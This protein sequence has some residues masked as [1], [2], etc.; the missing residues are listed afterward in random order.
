M[1]SKLRHGDTH[2][3]AETSLS[4]WDKS[5]YCKCRNLIGGSSI[6]Q[7]VNLCKLRCEKYGFRLIHFCPSLCLQ[8][9]FD[10]CERMLHW[11]SYWFWWH[12]SVV[13][14]FPWGEGRWTF[15]DIWFY[16]SVPLIEGRS[17]FLF[18][19]FFNIRDHF[20][21]SQSDFKEVE[22]MLLFFTLGK[23]G[24]GQCLSFRGQKPEG[25]SSGF[26]VRSP[27]ILHVGSLQGLL[28]EPLCKPGQQPGN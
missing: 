2:F 6:A 13:S 4:S 15:F 26:E 24:T 14:R 22:N 9:L 11:F 20:L 28:W 17:C 5:L 1:N 7:A 3:S 23:E 18:F 25:L 21:Y 16:F 19:F 12:F 27:W 8:V 10:E